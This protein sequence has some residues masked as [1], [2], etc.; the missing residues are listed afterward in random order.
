VTEAVPGIGHIL[1]FY[2]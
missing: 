2:W 1:C